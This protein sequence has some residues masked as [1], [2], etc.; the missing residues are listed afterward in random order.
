MFVS[1]LY[2]LAGGLLGVLATGRLDEIAWRFVRLAGVLALA[3]A[4]LPTA[5]SIKSDGFAL[6]SPHTLASGLGIAMAICAMLVV[7]LAP[8]GPNLLKLKRAVCFVGGVCGIIAAILSV[9]G[10]YSRLATGLLVGNELL[11]AMLLGSITLSWLLGHA[12]LTATKMTIAPL[13]HFSRVL[14]LAII[15]RIVFAL[16]SIGVALSISHGGNLD[17][18]TVLMTSVGLPAPIANQWLVLSL[19]GAVGL[20]S[21]AVFAYMVADC[22]KLRSTQSATGILYF[23]SVFA[24]VGELANLYLLMELGWPI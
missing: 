5:W 18:S 21:V 1:F 20:L 15:C 8:S 22:V 14:S 24:Y 12:Y 7:F 9:P 23:G 4:A 17:G 16:V 13:Q 19:R 11:A 3:S 10:D 6:N 2:S